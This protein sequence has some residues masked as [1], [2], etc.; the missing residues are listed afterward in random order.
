MLPNI[1]VLAASSS[2]KCNALLC[3]VTIYGNIT[4]YINIGVVI[5]LVLVIPPKLIMILILQYFL[6]FF[7]YLSVFITT[8]YFLFLK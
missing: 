4:S 7:Q 1:A 3:S 6:E 2:E 8:F 5:Q